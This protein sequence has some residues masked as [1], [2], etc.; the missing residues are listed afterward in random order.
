MRKLIYMLSFIVAACSAP[1]AERPVIVM[2]TS[3]GDIHI[4]IAVDSA[5]VTGT[6]FLRLAE[7]GHL[8]GAGFYRV[9]RPDNDNGTP[10]VSFVQGGVQ[11]RGSPFPAI[12]HE[13]TETTGLRH[14]DGA[15]SMAR[16]GVGTASSEF[17]ISVGA[18]PSLD[19]GGARNPDGQGFAVFGRVTDGMDVVHRIHALDADALTR[20]PYLAGQVLSNPVRIESV[21]ILD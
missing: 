17:F 4:E 19:F 12:P 16:A 18:Q 2:Q 20:N 10:T 11:H 13:T 6:N 15:V 5:P 7:G 14:V 1:S 9:V 8:D 21:R 3:L